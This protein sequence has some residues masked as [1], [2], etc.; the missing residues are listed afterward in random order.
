ME[1]QKKDLYFVSAVLALTL[2]AG[3]YFAYQHRAPSLERVAAHSADWLEGPRTT[4]R[5]MLERY[6]PP[7][8]LGEGTATWRE[9]GPWKRITI[10]GREHFSFLEQ[11]VSYHVPEEAAPAL[12][13]FGHGLRF[14][15]LNEEITAKSNAEAL[16]ILALNL[17][18]EMASARRAAPEASAFYVRTARLSAA[19]KSSPYLERLMFEPYRPLPEA[20]WNREIGY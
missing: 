7:Q 15:R 9:R 12:R 11:T 8:V 2:G 5:V 4:L 20:P 1:S 3:G 10:H 19:G 13:E 14:D 16:N 18:D 17:A 6:G